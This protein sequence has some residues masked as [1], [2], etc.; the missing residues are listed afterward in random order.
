MPTPQTLDNQIVDYNGRKMTYARMKY[1]MT[2]TQ[3]AVLK[4]VND[5]VVDEATLLGN[6]GEAL[7]QQEYGGYLR[8][9]V[10][11]L[12][13]K[14]GKVNANAAVDFYNESRDQW[15][16]TRSASL[17]RQYRKNQNRMAGRNASARLKSEIA[18]AKGYQAQFKDTY[19][20]IGKS[21]AVINYAMK[22]RAKY[23]HEPSVRAMG[24]ALTREVASYHRDTVL[25]NSALDPYVQKVQRVAQA[26]ACEFCRLMALGSRGRELGVTTYAVHFHAHCHCT[27]QPLYE[28]EEPVRPDYYDEFEKEYIEASRDGTSADSVLANWRKDLKA[29][30]APSSLPKI[31]NMLKLDEA[32]LLGEFDK[33]YGSQKFAGFSVVGKSAIHSKNF[34]AENALL[35][36][37]KILNS[38]GKSVGKVTRIFTDTAD[39][40]VVKHD[41]LELRPDAR[42]QGFGTEF[43][44]WSEDWYKQ[45]G[46]KRIDIFAALD[47]GG[48][49]WAKA[50]YDFAKKPDYLI[51]RLRSKAV[52]IKVEGVV[53]GVAKSGQSA[54]SNE[55][56]DRLNA[57][58][59]KLENTDFSSPDYPTPAELANMT[60]PSI[61]GIPWARWALQKGAWLGKKE[62]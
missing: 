7:A 9:V 42:G 27:I 25:F 3:E 8:T 51:M 44:K 26:G 22:V 54:A 10:P 37:G 33:A 16:S 45:N 12:I 57:I 14:Y 13:D 31:K 43:S 36:E 17:S 53:D 39:G 41:H 19:D 1:E 28:G 40:L 58:A 46:V 55:I 6:V 49:T 34:S 29:K 2:R 23:G 52:N 30:G 15:W 5:V 38:K 11:N 61:D 18:V 62:L 48:Y 24:N 59:D 4:H 50:G 47:D 20:E 56:A 32:D 35:F 21:D 60:G